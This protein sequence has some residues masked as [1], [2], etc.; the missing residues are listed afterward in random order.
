MFLDGG[1]SVVAVGGHRSSAS[2]IEMLTETW[3]WEPQR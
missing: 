3:V 2:G 1:D